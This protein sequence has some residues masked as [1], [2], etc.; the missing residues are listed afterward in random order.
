VSRWHGFCLHLDTSALR[1]TPIVD[2]LMCGVQQASLWLSWLPR[3]SVFSDGHTHIISVPVVA[4]CHAVRQARGRAGWVGWGGVGGRVSVVLP[5]VGVLQL[6]V[7]CM[8][9]FDQAWEFWSSLQLLFTG[10]PMRC[11]LGVSICVCAACACRQ[12]GGSC[13]CDKLMSL[14]QA[15]TVVSVLRYLGCVGRRHT[16]DWQRRWR[17]TVYPHPAIWFLQPCAQTAAG[18]A[19]Q[20]CQWPCISQ[21]QQSAICRASIAHSQS[22]Y[23]CRRWA[24]SVGQPMFLSGGCGQAGRQAGRQGLHSALKVADAVAPQLVAS[25][26][27]IVTCTVQGGLTLWVGELEFFSRHITHTLQ[28]LAFGVPVSQSCCLDDGLCGLSGCVAV[29]FLP[30]LQGWVE[31]CCMQSACCRGVPVT[32]NSFTLLAL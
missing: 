23:H 17:R 9:V 22:L 15:A 31:C 28:S 24:L 3:C 11:S 7:R 21:Q 29:R 20:H 14:G 12:G 30:V 1:G 25:A 27:A 10:R 18:C 5:H 8:L 19:R 6:A 32:A 13:I 16:Q 2:G 4:C 26:K